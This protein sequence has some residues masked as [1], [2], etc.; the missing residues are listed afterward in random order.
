MAPRQPGACT[1]PHR[2][3]ELGV[4]AQVENLYVTLRIRPAAPCVL[5]RAALQALPDASRHQLSQPCAQVLRHTMARLM[6]LDDDAAA[7]AVAA[8]MGG[9][10]TLQ[11][12]VAAEVQRL[13]AEAADHVAGLEDEGTPDA[14]LLEQR[15]QQLLQ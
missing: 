2:T 12:T 7:R 14:V 13:V 15:A 1:A 11:P 10:A 9:C 6:E 3:G 5:V 4:C 8:V